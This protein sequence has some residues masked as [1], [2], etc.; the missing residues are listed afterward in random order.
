MNKIIEL[1]NISKSFDGETVLDGISLDIHDNEFITLLGPSGCGKTT[2]LRIIGGFE[3]P[4][5]GDVIFMGEKINNVPPHKRHVN[6][7][8]QRYALFPHLNVF[9]NVAFPLRERKVPRKEIK[10]KVDRMLK[11]VMLSGFAER[12]V[13]SLSGGQQQRVAIARALVNEPKHQQENAKR[14]QQNAEGAILPRIRLP[15]LQHFI[16]GGFLF[17]TDLMDVG[18]AG[19]RHRHRRPCSAVA[20]L[21]YSCALHADAGG[22]SRLAGGDFCRANIQGFSY[23]H[24][25]IYPPIQREGC[26]SRAA[27]PLFGFIGGDPQP[28]FHIFFL[29]RN[30]QIKKLRTRPPLLFFQCQADDPVQHGGFLPISRYQ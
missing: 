16:A 10:E 2:T 19:A 4:D 5:Q 28:P 7:V 25:H 18:N 6:T 1:K 23:S 12:R 29:C 13:T 15:S 3:T 27:L 17:A 14:N 20:H 8:F 11:M 30:F 24:S 22:K 9:E 26:P 21:A